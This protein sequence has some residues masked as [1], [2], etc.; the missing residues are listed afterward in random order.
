MQLF[1][2][3]FRYKQSATPSGADAGVTAYDEVDARA[4][5]E[6]AFGDIDVMKVEVV[7]D[8]RKLDQSLVRAHMG[9]FLFRGVWFPRGYELSMQRASEDGSGKVTPFRHRPLMGRPWE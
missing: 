3:S 7:D 5:V 4:L 8:L 9:N 6:I 2:V 1:W